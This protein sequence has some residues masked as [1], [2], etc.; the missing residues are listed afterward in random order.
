VI[1]GKFALVD[2]GAGIDPAAG[3]R[4]A[5]A[6]QRQVREHF[7]P[8]WGFGYQVEV[9][10]ATAA[11]PLAPDECPVYLLADVTEKDRLGSHSIEGGR[12]SARVYVLLAER[13][14]RSWTAIASHEILEVLADP[15]LRLCVEMSDGFWDR[16]VAD[17]VQA[18]TYVIDGVE[19]SNFN[20][21]AC[22]EPDAGGKFDHMGTST[23]PNEIR[24]GGYAQRRSWFGW[25]IVGEPD[26][27]RAAL[28]AAGVSRGSARRSRS[29]LGRLLSRLS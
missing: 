1:P 27:Y 4:V 15:W 13:C 22:F 26:A 11:A 21:P 9:R 6:I 20:Y 5:A 28:S 18:E 10:A 17:R 2:A 12:P 3:G 16:E 29:W 7:A 25:R 14:G 23:R 24:P 8:A 19:V